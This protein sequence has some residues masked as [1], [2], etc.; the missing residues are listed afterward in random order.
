VKEK[1]F[2]TGYPSGDAEIAFVGTGEFFRKTLEKVFDMFCFR[3]IYLMCVNSLE[4]RR[5]KR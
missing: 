2:Q 5:I 4:L 1:D 3:V